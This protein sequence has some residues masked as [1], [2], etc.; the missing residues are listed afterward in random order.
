MTSEYIENKL[1]VV[2]IAPGHDHLDQRVRR[3]VQV[4]RELNFSVDLFFEN[5]RVEDKILDSNV[6]AYD[7]IGILSVIFG[8]RATFSSEMK[9]KVSEAD[10]IYI[11]DSGLY[12][13]RLLRILLKFNTKAIVIFDYHDWAAWE[14]VHHSRKLSSNK[15]FLSIL[16]YLA[17]K[18]LQ[19]TY[20][21]RPKIDALIG[22]TNSQ[23]EC[24]EKTF[25]YK[26][27][28]AKCAVANTRP[29]I[30]ELQYESEEI[31]PTLNLIWIG[32]VGLGRGFEEVV[33]MRDSILKSNLV[34]C[35]EINLT[36]FGKVWGKQTFSSLDDLDFRGSF[37]NDTE[38][39]QKMPRTRLV[40]IFQGWDD[41]HDTKINEIASPNKV[42]SYLNLGIPFLINNKLTDFIQVAN[43]PDCFVYR[44][45]GDF[46]EKIAYLNKN[47]LES[48]E[49]V[50]ELRNNVSWDA[51]ESQR[52][53]TF[54]ADVTGAR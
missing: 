24:F 38:I 51:D 34:Q 25:G 22:I 21:F 47:Y 40:G 10:I 41:T 8:F 31:D 17:E 33:S 23:L 9:S 53:K 37:K 19:K 45:S 20:L 18:V 44:D 48:R 14:V 42:Y 12:G 52:I 5:H 2:M 29:K 32:N 3:S 16:T 30:I 27:E 50:L 43:V 15:Y 13:L 35:N 36:V 26:R 49:L 7:A 6:Y 46:L 39:Y 11:H 28:I 54:L 1:K 4:L